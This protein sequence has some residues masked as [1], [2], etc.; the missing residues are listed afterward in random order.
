MV[1]KVWSRVRNRRGTGRSDSRHA[2]VRSV[3]RDA[4]PAFAERW[5][6]D[7]PPAPAKNR[8]PLALVVVAIVA[9]A[10]LYFGFH[11]A[12]RGGADNAA[13]PILGKSTPA[14]DF[15]LDKSVGGRAKAFRPARQSRA[16]EF[17]GDLVR[18]L[19]D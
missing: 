7:P 16:V 1:S 9:A 13:P 18:P 10:M 12:R 19:Q 11:M 5:C 15:T 2:D 14:P 4:S 17:L 8:N 6:S 3:R